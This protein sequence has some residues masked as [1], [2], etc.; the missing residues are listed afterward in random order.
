MEG[1]TVIMIDPPTLRNL[2]EGITHFIIF[3]YNSTAPI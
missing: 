1:G 2:V 3:E